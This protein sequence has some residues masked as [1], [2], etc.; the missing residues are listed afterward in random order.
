MRGRFFTEQELAC[1]HCG[2]NKCQQELIDL[3]DELREEIGRPITLN[4]AYRC[5]VHDKAEGGKGR[6]QT[7]YAADVRV[8]NST[9]RYEIVRL[10]FLV[11]FTGIGVAKNFV[12]L[13][14]VPKTAGYASRVLWLY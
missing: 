11:G 3:L 8:E 10:G 7:G 2:E 14:V 1:K 12:H 6:H 9:E 5:E 4:S 13:D